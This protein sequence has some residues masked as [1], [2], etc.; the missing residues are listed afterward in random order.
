MISICIPT[1]NRSTYLKRLLD[2]IL[3]QNIPSLEVIIVNDGSSDDTIAVIESFRDYLNL[4]IYTQNNQGRANALKKAINLST[5]EY[6]IFMDDED[7]FIEGALKEVMKDLKLLSLE[8][9]ESISGLVYLTNDINGS[10][11]GNSF[12][13]DNMISN[14]VEIVA[15]FKSVGD[16]KQVIKSKL[17]KEIL[18]KNIRNE[19]RVPTSILWCR[20]SNNYKCRFFNK[21]IVVKDYLDG[22]MTKNINRLRRKSPY[23]SRQIYKE[24]SNQ[25]NVYKSKKFKLKS[26]I[27]FYKYNFYCQEKTTISPSLIY[28]IIALPISFVYI[29][30]DLFSDLIYK[31]KNG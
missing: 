4:I 11:I 2:N 22:G 31:F 13:K 29:V 15:D 6:L 8:K 1:F 14:L 12:K 20:I 23:S 26:V 18:Y 10:N 16:K 24:L 5:N 19:R 27:L 9:E 28:K 3:L 30:I 21:P 7:Y 17:I 25:N